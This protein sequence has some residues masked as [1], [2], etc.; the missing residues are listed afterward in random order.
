[1]GNTCGC[2]QETLAVEQANEFDCSAA[3]D[4]PNQLDDPR[5]LESACGE[6]CLSTEQ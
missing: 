6:D 5:K 4:K 1:M 2:N 3:K